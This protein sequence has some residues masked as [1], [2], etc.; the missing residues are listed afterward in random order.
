MDAPVSP[1]SKGSDNF[2]KGITDDI[3]Q[4]YRDRLFDVNKDQLKATAEKYV[5]FDH[6]SKRIVWLMACFHL[7][8]T[9]KKWAWGQG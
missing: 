9:P 2:L 7:A 3:K 4:R 6:S 1:G 5:H 8:L